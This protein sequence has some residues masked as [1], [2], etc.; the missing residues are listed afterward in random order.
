[1]VA[2][3]IGN[4]TC[5]ETESNNQFHMEITWLKNGINTARYL[6]FFFIY[7]LF[8]YTNMSDLGRKDFSDKVSEAVK[9]ESEK[10]T[11]E[12]TKNT[13]TDKLD[14]Y[15]G[16]GTP[17][18]QKSFTQSAADHAKQGHD[19]AKDAVNKDQQTLADTA[20]QYVDA[21]KEQ[22]GNAAEYVSS[23]VTGATEGAKTGAETKK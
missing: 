18:N 12:Q 2:N 7:S 10:S 20:A 4:K 3:V 19:D 14:E 8:K 17:D 21:A 11:L 6:L 1:M 22:V 13:V 16:K 15:A 23:I 9:P 5:A